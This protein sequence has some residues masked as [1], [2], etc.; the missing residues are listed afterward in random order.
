[1]ITAMKSWSTPLGV[2][3]RPAALFI[4]PAPHVRALRFGGLGFNLWGLRI[5]GA[6][7]ALEGFRVGLFIFSV[8]LQG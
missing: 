3:V 4:A 8:K 2:G 5:T 1:M 7:F 6:G